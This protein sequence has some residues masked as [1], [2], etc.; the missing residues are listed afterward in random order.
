MRQFL[1]FV[2]NCWDLFWVLRTRRPQQVSICSLG[3]IIR[4]FSST[5]SL[6]WASS[7]NAL[8]AEC[9]NAMT[10]SVKKCD[11]IVMEAV[12]VTPYELWRLNVLKLTVTFQAKIKR[13]RKES[14]FAWIN[15]HY[16]IIFMIIKHIS[17]LRFSLL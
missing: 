3:E 11:V 13:K 17:P 12:D 14:D 16:T 7:W 1:T 5:S 15:L 10:V 4:N 9:V 2:N 8:P 6:S